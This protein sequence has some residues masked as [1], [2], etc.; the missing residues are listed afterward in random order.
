MLFYTLDVATPKI[1]EK[2]LVITTTYD[3]WH[4]FTVWFTNTTTL[5]SNFK[6]VHGNRSIVFFM[7]S[8]STPYIG[9]VMDHG[10]NTPLNVK[11]NA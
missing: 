6:W 1:T 7:G 8:L 9:M 2:I 5:F 4:C 10:S 3:C 11:L